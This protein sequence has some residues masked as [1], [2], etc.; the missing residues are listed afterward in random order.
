MSFTMQQPLRLKNPFSASRLLQLQPQP[1]QQQA[2]SLLT[3]PVE[4]PGE[5][6]CAETGLKEAA[7]LCTDGAGIRKFMQERVRE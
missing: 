1:Q 6:Q 2:L 7:V 3:E 4:Q 5:I